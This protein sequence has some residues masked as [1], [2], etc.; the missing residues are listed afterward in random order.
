MQKE[1]EQIVEYLNSIPQFMEGYG[2][3]RSAKMLRELGNPETSLKMIHV[4]GTN[5]KGSVSLYIHDILKANG[6]VTGLF[7]SPHLTDIRE[8]V[9]INGSLIS[10]EDFVDCFKQVK[11]AD[12][13]L[14]GG[15][16]AYF[17]YMLGIAVLAFKKNGTDFAVIETGLGGRLDSTNALKTPLASLI[18]TISLE[19]TAILGDT[20]E[21]IASEKA[22]IIK[23]GQIFV[24]LDGR[25]TA[26]DDIIKSVA[27]NCGCSMISALRSDIINYK[28]EGNCIDFCVSNR[29]YSN[30]CFRIST[31]AVYQ[32]DNCL[33]ALTLTAALE[34]REII[35]TDKAKIGLALENACWHGRMER[36]ADNVYVDGAHNPEGIKAFVESVPYIAGNR[37]S[38]LLFSVVNDK[39][40]DSMAKTICDS[41]EFD[42][43]LVT[44]IEGS[45]QLD[46]DIIK[47]SFT[48]NGMTD[49]AVYDTIETAFE[50][51]K[52]TVDELSGVLFVAG[53]L[54]LVGDIC[55]LCGGI[56]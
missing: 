32:M 8:R 19:H 38:V 1:Y 28:N 36:V 27:K 35:H 20:I 53:S 55:R 17:D 21:K 7:T 22:G 56:D 4:A 10:R 16:L 2:V 49:V 3:D 44:A 31:G 34:E 14:G 41:G 42:A 43:V 5:G 26:A 6:Y 23:N 47:K 30:D 9:Q 45:R 11:K 39:N 37:K 51:A 24:Y 29:Y 13:S 18:T 25:N 33:E 46:T 12:E 52:E 48:D 15:R 40:F 54:Y 50:H